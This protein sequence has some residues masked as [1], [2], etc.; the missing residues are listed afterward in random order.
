[1]SVYLSQTR[2]RRTKQCI[3]STYERVS[4][5]MQTHVSK[6]VSE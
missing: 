5:W 6:Q 3:E 1:M 2:V 4:K